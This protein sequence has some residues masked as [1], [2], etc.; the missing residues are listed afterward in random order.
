[1]CI[2]LPVREAGEGA[3]SLFCGCLHITDSRETVCAKPVREVGEG[4]AFY[5][6]F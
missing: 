6:M 2:S 3:A 5:S 4:A 1:M